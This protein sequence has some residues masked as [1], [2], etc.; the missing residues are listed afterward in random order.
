MRHAADDIESGFVQM[1]RRRREAMC[2][3]QVRSALGKSL[4]PSSA[5]ELDTKSVIML[6][7]RLRVDRHRDK[8]V[9]DIER[10][11]AQSIRG[12]T[13]VG[14]RGGRHRQVETEARPTAGPRGATDVSGDGRLQHLHEGLH[15]D[16]VTAEVGSGEAARLQRDGDFRLEGKGTNRT[17]VFVRQ[18]MGLPSRTMTTRTTGWLALTPTGTRSE[19]TFRV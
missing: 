11:L 12:E 17:H 5:E 19:V 3:S 10:R 6:I 7:V 14:H 1:K 18:V 9:I 15:Q 8:I 2:R 16:T 4:D 13:P